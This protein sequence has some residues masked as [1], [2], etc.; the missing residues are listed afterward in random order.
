MYHR[1]Y[2]GF[3]EREFSAEEKKVDGKRGPAAAG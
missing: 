1:D 3:I 2:L